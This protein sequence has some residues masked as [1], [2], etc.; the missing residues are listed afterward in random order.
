MPE[1]KS[2]IQLPS[3]DN[4][5]IVLVVLSNIKFLY[6]STLIWVCYPVLWVNT[7]DS[8]TSIEIKECGA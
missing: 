5:V 1:N 6:G 2:N 7:F 8:P 3:L 4:K